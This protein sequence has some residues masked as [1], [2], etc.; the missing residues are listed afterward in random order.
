VAASP[1]ARLVTVA[2]DVDGRRVRVLDEGSGPTVVLEAGAGATLDSWARVIPLLTGDVRVIAYDRPGLGFSDPVAAP[3]DRRPRAVA[4]RLDALLRVAAAPPPYVLVGHSLGGLYVRAL[5]ERCPDAV[6]GLV[7][8]DP[9]HEDMQRAMMPSWPERALG[10]AAQGLIGVAA[11]LAPLGAGRLLAPLVMP[12]EAVQQLDLD[13]ALRDALRQRYMQGDALRAI[14]RELAQL[15]ASLDQARTLAV[16]PSI[17]VTV[18]SGDRLRKGGD[19]TKRLVVNEL[20]VALAAAS[21]TGRH[22]VVPDCG[23]LVPIEHP[24]AVADAVLG[25]L[26]V[27]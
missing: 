13:P 5:A 4:A 3:D 25:L 15:P 22:V 7:L 21:E 26:P 17:P 2:L 8:V 23:H 12:R 16:P 1:P 24:D 11:A 19:Q 20:H 14:Y 9:S 6:A 27:G 10:V 18:L